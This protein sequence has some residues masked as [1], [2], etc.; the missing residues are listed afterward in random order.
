M[1]PSMSVSGRALRK[2]RTFSS[3]CIDRSEAGV[4]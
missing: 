3:F 1:A 2:L 4:L